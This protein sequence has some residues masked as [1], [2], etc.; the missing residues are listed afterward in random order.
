MDSK[1]G[2]TDNLMWPLG[3]PGTPQTDTFGNS[4]LS[5]FDAVV[6]VSRSEADAQKTQFDNPVPVLFPRHMAAPEG[7]ETLDMR[8]L[9]VMNAGEVN[10]TLFSFTC[11]EGATTMLYSYAIFT[12]AINAADILFLPLLDGQRILG[13]HGDPADNFK[14]NLAVG[15]DLAQQSLIPCQIFMQ[16]KQK[17]TW[18]LSNSGAQPASMGVRMVGYIDFGQRLTASKLG[19]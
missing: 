14:I 2:L 5:P 19:G 10:Y 16:P 11:P 6:P 17:L 9:A 13:Y 3:K 4:R 15:A 8:R 18:V 1:R 7:A 12:D